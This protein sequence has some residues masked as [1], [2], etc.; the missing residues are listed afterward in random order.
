MCCIIELLIKLVKCLVNFKCT[1][2]IIFLEACIGHAQPKSYNNGQ[3]RQVK[4]G[5]S[6]FSI[7]NRSAALDTS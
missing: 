3:S 5:N 2:I 4:I 1:V 7:G 6:E